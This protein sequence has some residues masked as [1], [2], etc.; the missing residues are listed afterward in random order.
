MKVVSIIGWEG[1]RWM[2]GKQRGH[3]NK[4][5]VIGGSHSKMSIGLWRS[6]FGSFCEGSMGILGGPLRCALGPVS[7]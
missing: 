7:S 1:T 6:S 4:G 5:I 2:E 3:G